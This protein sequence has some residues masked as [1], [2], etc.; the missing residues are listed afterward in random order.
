MA[1]LRRRDDHLNGL[2]VCRIVRERI[3]A[4]ETRIPDAAS[5]EFGFNSLEK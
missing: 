5:P 2:F 1:K 3:L 4:A